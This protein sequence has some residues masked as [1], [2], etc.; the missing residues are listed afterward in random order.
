M[1]STH[2]SLV[3]VMARPVR[4]TT[5]VWSVTF[6]GRWYYKPA[7]KALKPDTNGNDLATAREP[8]LT[9]HNAN[10]TD[11]LPTD[12]SEYQTAEA[13]RNGMPHRPR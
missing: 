5:C 2:R 11:G 7:G 4:V 9:P 13:Q 8:V 12:G 1:S 10:L 6:I 3:R